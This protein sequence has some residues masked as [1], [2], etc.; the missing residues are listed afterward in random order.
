MH[1]E[2]AALP[3]PDL[4]YA[5][6]SVYL[7]L[8][9][10]AGVHHDP[11]WLPEIGF[12]LDRT[13]HP[14]SALAAYEEYLGSTW[15]YRLIFDPLK[16]VPVLRRTGEIYESR[17]DTTHAIRA[18]ER[19]VTLWRDADPVLQPQVSEIKRRL[20]ELTAEPH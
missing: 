4:A 1:V 19:I 7:E 12:A 14:D 9:E 8:V 2:H 17:G 3:E 10:P 5:E 15:N 16:L 6:L 13:G 11:G 18:Y 20:A